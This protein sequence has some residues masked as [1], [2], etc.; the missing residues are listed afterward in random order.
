MAG[1]G[2]PRRAAPGGRTRWVIVALLFAITTVNYMD[3]NLL[4][5]LKP[6]IQGELHFSESDYGDIVFAFSI[7]YAAGYAGMGAFTDKVGIRIGL[8][9][10]A[11]VWSVASAAHGLV[12]SVTGFTLARVMLGLG[13]GGNFP[14]CIK[15][16]ATW[17]PR[18]DRALA[19]G[20][21]NSGSNI[22]GLL[23]PLIAAFVTATWGWQAAFYV[24]GA[25]GLLWLV[26]WLGL[27]RAPEVHPDVTPEELAYIRSDP[28]PP[29]ER[30]PWTA[31]LAYAGTWTYIV[32]GVLTN[33][34]WWFYNNW[35]PSF[36]FD[37]FHVNLL[38][39]G[40][41]L[42]VI[43]LMTDVGSIG[44]GWLS[45]RLIRAGFG[46][47]TARKLALLACAICTVPVFLA[48]RVEGI[49]TAVLLIGLAMAAHQGFSANLFTLVSDTMPKGAIAGAVGLGGCISSILSGFSAK[50]VGRILDATG[51]NYT[52]VFFVGAGA[53]LVAVLA[54]HLL[55]PRRDAAA[56]GVAQAAE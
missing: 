11:M 41:P 30:V 24:S 2:D 43:Y 39:L 34:V 46:V 27:Y 16:V 1:T 51:G 25:V 52:L 4:G 45:G 9:V 53:Y 23:A 56:E 33:P 14:T 18:R 28:E 31:L 48:P 5:V 19:T 50:V 15:T 10:A 36:L 7:A 21:F 3:R 54:V 49:W 55:L 37:R 20:V 47:F 17:F 22:G 12:A 44:G 40:L 35:V 38:A 8:A 29:V 32:G 13:E 26:F 6:T 42:V